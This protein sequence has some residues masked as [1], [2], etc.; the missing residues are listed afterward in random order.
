MSIIKDLLMLLNREFPTSAL[1]KR[2]LKVGKNFYRHQGCFIDP[3]H[4]FL[5]TIGDDVTMSVHVTILAHD[6][7]TK[8]YLG[9]TKIG[10]VRIGNNVFIGANVTILPGVTI[11][12]N[13]VI[14]AGSVVTKDI[15]A[16]TVAAGS[17]ASVLMSAED[18]A[19][20]NAAIMNGCGNVFDRTYR[21]GKTLPSEKMQQMICATEQGIAFIE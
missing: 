1:I 2:G 4:C 14:G 7:S 16:G 5:I 8:K 17:P 11:G 12:D 15:P 9:Y 19:Q 6:A 21:Y 18:F 3:S 13:A 20:K 10:Q